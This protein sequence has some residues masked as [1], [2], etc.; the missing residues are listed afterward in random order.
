M[1]G[2]SRTLSEPFDLDGDGVVSPWEKHL[3]KLCLFGALVI[4]FGDKAISI[5]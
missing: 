4:A 2:P 1:S 3:C 5:I